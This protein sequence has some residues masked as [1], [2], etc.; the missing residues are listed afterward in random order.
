[1]ADAFTDERV[2]RADAGRGE[3]NR[4]GMLDA[5]MAAGSGGTG[6]AALAARRLDFRGPV[7]PA[8]LDPLAG[9][10]S[11]ILSRSCVQSG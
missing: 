3:M 5:A 1:M 10:L 6:E 2:E 7:A 4:P 8:S 9:V 11:T